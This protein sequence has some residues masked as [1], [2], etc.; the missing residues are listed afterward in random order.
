[1]FKPFVFAAALTSGL[2]ASHIV[3]DE[4]FSMEQVDGTV[5]SPK[6]FDPDY[7]GP[8]AYR[9]VLKNSVNIPT[10]K[11][12]LEVGLESVIQQA[13][14]MGIETPIPAYPSTSIGAADVIPLQVAE[15]YSTIATGGVRPTPFSI[16]KVEDAEGRVIFETRPRRTVV[17]D[18][19]TTAILRDLMRT[20]VDN[21]SGYAARDPSLGNLPYDIPAAGKTGTN[22]DATDIWFAGFTPNL[23]GV[24]WF[25]FDKP[26]TIVRTAAGGIY[27]APVWGQFMRLV[28]YG[29]PP[30]LAKPA[31]WTLPANVVT[32]EIDRLSGKLTGA[33]CAPAD[34]R[35]ELFVSGTEP[36]SVCDLHGPPLLGD[37]FGNH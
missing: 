6:N 19:A 11:L 15:A 1:V 5:W 25:G 22:N 16:L 31:Q 26:K 17:A 34:R 21:G 32:R 3:V 12:G 24:V 14:R 13:R 30:L 2:P 8:L 37:P 9:E 27:A 20:V 4:P 18:S 36:T 7:R 23:L 35:N 28:Y 29:K 33:A 10:I